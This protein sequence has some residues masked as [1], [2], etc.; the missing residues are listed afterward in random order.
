MNALFLTIAIKAFDYKMIIA[1]NG[2]KFRKRH[3]DSRSII[4]IAFHHAKR[5]TK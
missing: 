4:F 1:L 2:I 5:R 3:G